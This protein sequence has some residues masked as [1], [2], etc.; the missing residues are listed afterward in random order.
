MLILIV[1]LTC[2][3]IIIGVILNRIT[4]YSI[5]KNTHRAKDIATIM[6]RTLND[7]NYVVRLNLKNHQAYNLYG[8]FLP[9]NGM[10]FE[11]SLEYI[12]PDDQHLYEEFI[13]RLV[14]GAES[15]ECTFRWD[16]S[17]DKHENNWRYIHD[18]GIVEYDEGDKKKPINFYCSLNDQT[19]LIETEE[20]ERAL[21]ERYRKLFEQSIVG[22][23]F[24]DKDGHLLTA[25][26]KLREILKFKMNE[27]KF[28]HNYTLFEIPM[29]QNVLQKDLTD[30]LYFCTKMSIFE[31]NVNCYAE[32]RIHP[33]YN[34]IHELEFFT[35]Y[36]R[37]ISQERDLY[38]QDKENEASLH[39]TNQEIEQY[40]TQLKYLME[41]IDMRFF[42][43]SFEKQEVTFYRAMNVIEGKMGFEQLITHF[44]DDPFAEGLRHPYEFFN[45]PKS[46][47]TH[48]RPFFDESTQLQ[49]NFIDSIPFYNEEG[50]QTGTYGVIRNVTNLINKQNQLKEETERANQSGIRKSTF[51]A[52]M[53]H[54]IRTPL[55]A[56]VGFSDVLATMSTPEERE[57]IIQVISNN[58]ELLL[59]LVNDILVLSSLEN[60]N[61]LVTPTKT[62]FAKCFESVSTS[63][64]QQVKNPEVKF[65]IEN[66]Y[67][68]FITTIDSGRIQQVITNFV[69]NAIKYTHQGHIKI[70]YEQQIRHEKDGLY[71][72]CEDTGDGIPKEHQSKVFDRFVK[73]NDFVQGTG[74]GLSIS[75]VIAHNSGGEIGVTSEGKGCGST[76]WIWIPCKQETTPDYEE[77]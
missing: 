46:T 60:G 25:N 12:H 70:G 38:L 21:T 37:D 44:I 77:I 23:A 27:D 34:E 59:R 76:F 62:D 10:A 33:I 54:E 56:I 74:L 1:I 3:V 48:M 32:I 18:I 14:K 41:N 50:K 42:R 52:S 20:D 68:T 64:A 47:L 35:L 53:S 55:N 15:S 49:W 66:P 11:R 63:L 4:L 8:D 36:I 45:E 43:T 51:L 7:N 26:Q 30:D 65:I 73:L 22:Q 69:T 2:V 75:K 6:Q 16:S 28:Y 13:I 29:F 71:I 39:R 5:R 61:I 24:Y 31:R 19:E 67:P 17:L 57:G 72:Y 40:E 9:A 58:C